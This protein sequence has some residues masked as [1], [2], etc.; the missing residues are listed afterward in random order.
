[1]K[2]LD[3]HVHFDGG[4]PVKIAEMA[5]IARRD[6][7]YLALS[8]GLHY[9]AHDFLPNEEVLQWCKKYPDVFLPLAKFELWDAV[10]PELIG[11]WKEQGFKGV[12]FIYPYY[13]YDHDL[14]MPVY[15][16]CE[17]YDMPVLFH[18]GNYRPNAEDIRC[19]RPILKNMNPL[20]LD[21]IA[22]SFQKLH[23]VMAHL[24]TRVWRAQAVELIGMHANLYA[25]LAGSGSW[26]GISPQDLNAMMQPFPA[27]F[28]PGDDPF[29][30]YRKLVF[31]SDGYVM[32]PGAH[33][34]GLDYYERTL[35]LNAVP[36]D[37]RFGIMGGT[38]ASWMGLE[39][40]R[41]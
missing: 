2:R 18:T 32:R 28:R 6:E 23:I 11:R 7:C 14:Y 21:R 40:D 27:Y 3:F 31:G 34:M 24:G 30:N 19:R 17:K 16:A 37:V 36:E 41:G 13:E 38:V 15:E 10:R 22:R 9:G 1:M 12:K 39:L 26:L 25:D 8:G 5:E 35:M 33:T 20:N 29:R 4:D